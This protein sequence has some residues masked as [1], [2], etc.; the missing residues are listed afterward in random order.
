M[1]IP[2]TSLSGK[3][4]AVFFEGETVSLDTKVLP[5]EASNARVTYQISNSNVAT[6][7]ADGKVTGVHAG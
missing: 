1:N 2:V 7:S 4:E 5:L 6:V 3:E